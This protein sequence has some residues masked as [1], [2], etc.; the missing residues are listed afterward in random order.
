MTAADDGLEDLVDRFLDR[1]EREPRL[2]AEAFAAE[3]PDAG[4]DL[5]AALRASLDVLATLGDSEPVPERI[6][7]FRVVR[8]LGRGGAGVVYEVE[9][10]GVHRALKRL[11][12]T[13]LLQPHAQLRFQR[14]AK[15]LA[16][17]AHPGIVGVHEIGVADGLPFL[18]MDLVPGRSLSGLGPLPWRHAVEL[19]RQIGC[20]L[21]AVH[22]AGLCHR[23]LKPQNVM[24]RD[25]GS[26]VIVDFGLVHDPL[27]V[28]LTGTGDLLGTPRYLAPEQADGLPADAR[29][30]LHAVGLILAELLTGRPARSGSDRSALLA[31]A[32]AGGAPD[33]PGADLPRDLVR[34]VRTATARHP[35]WRPAT[36]QALVADCD[37]LLTGRPVRARPPGLLVRALDATRRHPGRAAACGT[38]ALVLALAIAFAWQAAATRARREQAEA[39]F[40][41]AV[42]AF[43]EQDRA[44]LRHE[45]AAAVAAVPGHFGAAALQ[46]IDAGTA[47]PTIA[48]AGFTPWRD[49]LAARADARW[50]AAAAAFRTVLVGETRNPLAHLLVAEAEEK[51]GHLIE[52]ERELTTACALLPASAALAGALGNLHTRRGDAR[53]AA[54]AYR[55]AS[56]LRPDSPVWHLRLA[57]AYLSFD[58]AAG[59]DE[60]QAA[61]AQL[62]ADDDDQR[63]DL[64]LLRAALLDKLGRSA[65]AVAI[66]EQIVA[67]DPRDVRAQFNLGYA[68]DRLLRVREAKACYER[69]LVLEPHNRSAVLCLVWLLT[70]AEPDDLRDLDRAESLLLDVLRR[71]GGRSEAVRRMARDFALRTGRSTGVVEALTELM[72]NEP[73]AHERAA[74][75]HLR[76]NVRAGAPKAR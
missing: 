12:V 3:H 46:A 8:E 41:R 31:A 64:A 55:Q 34:L 76:N 4:P 22:G 72:A 27:D 9:R 67:R 10:D 32:K 28:T 74:L 61:T 63:A 45:L 1:R 14:E 26:P 24:L 70:T 35:R 2:T 62:A 43:C 49:A 50:D 19:C 5:L 42:L 73:S 75:E 44:T 13:T 6:A 33:L 30:D 25:D 66:L 51:A 60:V 16:R 57:R 52:A 7:D 20:A 38:A 54:V 11:S 36:A 71:D 48:A 18:V 29:T 59:L 65:E 58:A 37:R 56:S 39:H 23:D 17:I 68:L 15:A 47:P 21:A 40:D 69:V 53:A